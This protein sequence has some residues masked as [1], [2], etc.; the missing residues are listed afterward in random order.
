MADL[1]GGGVHRWTAP[2]PPVDATRL[3]RIHKYPDPTAVRPVIREAAERMVDLAAELAAPEAHAVAV[4]IETL[5]DGVLTLDSG[6][7][8]HCPAFAEHLEGATALLGFVLT[9]GP[10]LDQRVVSFLYDRFEP[11][12]ALFL[13]TAGWLTIEAATKRYTQELKRALAPAGWRLTLRMG[14]G[15]DY[16][17]PEGEGRVRWDLIEQH[18]LFAMFG[19]H[20]L[21]V[22][23]LESAA[24]QPKMSRSGAFGMIPTHTG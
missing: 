16:R 15:Y 23:L 4:P 3:L 21:P 2:P 20:P 22:A 13:E 1:L 9:I 10:D 7:R 8:F 18:D 12:D 14:P 17:A 5:A 19:N 24:M 6:I 11:L